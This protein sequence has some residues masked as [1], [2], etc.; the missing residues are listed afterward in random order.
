MADLPIACSIAAVVAL[1]VLYLIRPKRPV[2]PVFVVQPNSVEGYGTFKQ[3]EA[4]PNDANNTV[5][6]MA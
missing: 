3:D 2:V 4:I 1:V 6:V 5:Q